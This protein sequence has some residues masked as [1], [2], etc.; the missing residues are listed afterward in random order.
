MRR[1]LTLSLVGACGL[2]VASDALQDPFVQVWE[3]VAYPAGEIVDATD[4][5]GGAPFPGAPQPAGPGVVVG[6]LALLPGAAPGRYELRQATD[7]VGTFGPRATAVHDLTFTA[8]GS[9][10]GIAVAAGPGAPVGADSATVWVLST[11]AAGPDRGRYLCTGFLDGFMGLPNRVDWI[12]RFRPHH[13]P[14]PRERVWQQSLTLPPDAGLLPWAPTAGQNTGPNTDR[15]Q[16]RWDSMS[17]AVDGAAELPELLSVTLTAS[18]IVTTERPRPMRQVQHPL[19]W[20][21][22]W[23]EPDPAAPTIV[24]Q[25]ADAL[26]LASVSTQPAFAAHLDRERGRLLFLTEPVTLQRFT[27]TS[28]YAPGT[29]T[30]GAPTNQAPAVTTTYTGQLTWAVLLEEGSQG[31]VAYYALRVDAQP[32]SDAGAVLPLGAASWAQQPYAIGRGSV[33]RTIT[34]DAAPIV[35][36]PAPTQPPVVDFPAT[37]Q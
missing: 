32:R 8:A 14:L 15:T 11:T 37:P 17:V 20:W 27:T 16:V 19:F 18:R 33:V 25:H 21:V 4:A 29:P 9:P 3:A 5:P 28:T 10:A 7:T 12:V 2:A 22:T 13:A 34:P 23:E 26:V 6:R 30:S 36:P 24:D 35:A 31:L 1:V